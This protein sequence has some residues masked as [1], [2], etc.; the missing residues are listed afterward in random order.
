VTRTRVLAVVLVALLGIG[1][2]A[3][4]AYDQFL[5]GD[6]VPPLALATPPPSASIGP[7]TSTGS[8]AP[9]STA[10]PEGSLEPGDLPGAW[11][12]SDGSVAG[13]RVRE[14]LASLPAESDAVGR[15]DDITG[16][17][18][19]DAAADSIEVSSAAFEVDLTTLASD[20][21]RRDRRLSQLGI[22]SSTYPT[23][24]FTLTSPVAVPASALAAI[25]VDV[26][27]NGDLTL[28][29]ITK[30][31]EIPAQARLNGDRIE[32][33][34]SLTFPFATFDVTPPSIGGF[35]SVGDEATLEFL[36]SLERA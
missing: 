3:Y 33:Q 23:S 31:V 7:G 11:V 20:D 4:L 30:P 12:V 29:G 19:I 17:A 26:T 27:L 22:E 9:A 10:S 28:H 13:Y 1:A 24:T 14:K 5:R 35:V 36:V 8:A 32:V 6:N 15:T 18:T 2:A 25:T 16:G 34:G 21:G